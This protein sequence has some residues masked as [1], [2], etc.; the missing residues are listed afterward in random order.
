MG[1]SIY[2]PK[3]KSSAF[4]LRHKL[5]DPS[6]RLNVQRNENGWLADVSIIFFCIY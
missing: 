5:L 1:F 4:E 6:K 3:S 2:V